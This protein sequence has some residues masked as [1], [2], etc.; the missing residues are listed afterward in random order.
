MSAAGFAVAFVLA[1]AVF[2]RPDVE[3]ASNFDCISATIPS[4]VFGIGAAG[5]IAEVGS[6][7]KVPSVPSVVAS[8]GASCRGE[9]KPGEAGLAEAGEP[10]PPCPTI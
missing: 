10:K 2:G 5:T 6:A 7:V 9:P 1:D 8:L 4:A 3:P